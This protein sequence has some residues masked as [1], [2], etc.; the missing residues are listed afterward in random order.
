MTTEAIQLVS[1]IILGGA[2][3]GG[4]ILG[5]YVKFS[6]DIALLKQ[7]MDTEETHSER[8]VARHQEH[9]QRLNETVLSIERQLSEIKL[10]IEKKLK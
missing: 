6:T 7:R 1:G 8:F 3:L 9:D 10:L 5:I 4:T 2:G